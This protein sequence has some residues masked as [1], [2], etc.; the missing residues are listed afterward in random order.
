MRTSQ[1]TGVKSGCTG[2]TVFPFGE[3]IRGVRGYDH[4][5]TEHW[6]QEQPRRDHSSEPQRRNKS[7]HEESNRIHSQ[8]YVEHPQL[9]PRTSCEFE[10][11]KILAE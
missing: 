5:V 9:T 10:G 8:A 3:D 4:G 1:L 11:A 7:I 2:M 6:L